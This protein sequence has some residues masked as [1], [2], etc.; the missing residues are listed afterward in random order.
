MIP[1][2]DGMVYAAHRDGALLV[3]IRFT[4]MRSGLAVR[5]HVTRAKA[6]HGT[7]TEVTYR[8]GS[9]WEGTLTREVMAMVTAMLDACVAPLRA[10]APS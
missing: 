2:D 7:S 6:P 8:D 1:P 10:G 4:A 9:A 5:L 3:R